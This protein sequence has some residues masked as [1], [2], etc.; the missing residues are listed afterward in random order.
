MLLTVFDLLRFGLKFTPFTNK[1]YLFPQTRIIE[2]LQKNLGNAR[3]MTNDSRI[4]PPNFS[5]VYRLQSLDGY[6]P[7]YLQ[8]YGELIAA[9]ERGKPDISPPFG[10]NRIITPH[11]YSSTIIDLLGVKYILSLT[12]LESPKL[13]KVF[14][15]GETKV[16][17]NKNTFPRVFFVEQVI[18]ANDKNETIEKMF[19]E[20]FDPRRIAI[21]E[22]SAGVATN[23]PLGCTQCNAII[24]S[25]KENRVVIETENVEDGFLVL[26]DSFYPLWR[27]KID[28][29]PTT[30]YRADYNLRGINVPRGKHIVE[31]YTR[32]F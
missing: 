21:V 13:R 10:F 4:L 2:F 18:V 5:I 29:N 16:Y 27:A 15:E 25:Y 14:Q 23:P 22:K 3:V 6:D 32:L 26:T 9:S 7:L 1:E 17:E 28:N 19:E 12:E 30:I 24:V 11:N 20:I 31:F 8:R